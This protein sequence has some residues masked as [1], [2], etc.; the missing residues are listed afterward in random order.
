MFQHIYNIILVVLVLH[1]FYLISMKWLPFQIQKNLNLLS[2]KQDYI[3]IVYL[4]YSIS[5]SDYNQILHNVD[6]QII[7]KNYV[8]RY[9]NQTIHHYLAQ[10]DSL[11]SSYFFYS[12]L[13]LVQYPQNIQK[14]VQVYT[15][16][17]F[18][19]YLTKYLQ[20]MCCLIIYIW[21]NSLLN[22]MIP[23]SNY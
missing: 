19:M 7:L 1:I 6:I 20:L 2:N 3:L 13:T 9:I 22:Q 23:Y 14:D 16:Q 21:V 4:S 11:P 15:K 10:A 18:L 17:S 5:L 8:Y 12:K